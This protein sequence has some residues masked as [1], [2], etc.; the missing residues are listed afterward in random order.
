MTPLKHAFQKYRQFIL[1]CLVGAG[2][3]LITLLVY[4][5]LLRLGVPYIAANTAGYI[6]GVIHGYLWSTAVVFRARRG[7][8]NL[9][10]FLAV[11]IVVLG[12]SNGLIFLMVNFLHMPRTLAQ[13]PTLC[14]TMPLNFL[15]NKVWTFRAAAPKAGPPAGDNR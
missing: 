4:Q 5:G 14:V 12:V 9:G 2:N 1:F 6:C 15:L 11:N 7:A 10:K 13:I 3:T 8:T